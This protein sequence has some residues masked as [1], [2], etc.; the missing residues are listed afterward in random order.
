MKFA[1]KSIVAAAAF[2]AVGAASAATSTVL[3]GVETDGFVMTGSGALQFSKNLNA[4]LKLGGVAM[5]AYGTGATY[6]STGGLGYGYVSAPITSLTYDTTTGGVSEVV[7]AGGATQVMAANDLISAAGGSAKVGDLDVQF[8]AD[9]SVNIYGIVAGTSLNGTVVDYSGLL[10]TVTAANVSGVTTFTGAAGSYNTTLAG[11]K[12][13]DA[14]FNALV[15]VF[16]LDPAGLGYT[17]LQGAT[18]NFGTLVSTINVTAVTPSVPEPSTY[19]LM[20]IG[21]VGVGLMARRRRAA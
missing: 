2:V 15:D 7:S 10:F 6:T 9:G 14:G 18:T 5:G 1:L 16:G 19:A 11:L 3:S 21:L 20:G 8:Q 17:S 4:A 12:I 13:T